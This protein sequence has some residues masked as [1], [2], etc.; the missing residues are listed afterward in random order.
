MKKIVLLLGII[1]LFAAGLRLYPSLI[2][3]MPFS[4]DAWSPIKNAELLMQ[5]TP[6][7]LN[8]KIFDGYNNYWPINSIFGALISEII[9]LPPIDSMPLLF[10]IVGALS[11]LI[12]YAIVNIFTGP[13]IS[14]LACLLFG[15]AFSHTYFT[16]GI[17]KETYASP[18]YLLLI[19]VFIH[20][21]LGSSKRVFLFTL[22][23]IALSLTHHLTLLFAFFILLSIALAKFVVN[24][25]KG[26]PVNRLELLLIFIPVLVNILYYELYANAGMGLP[27]TISDWLSIASFQLLAFTTAIFIALKPPAP[28]NSQLYLI[29][30]GSAILAGILLIV[31]LNATLV[32]GFDPAVQNQLLLFILPYFI[33]IPFEVLGVEYQKRIQ[34]L[35]IPLFW[36]IPLAA[37]L[38]YAVVSNTFIGS[39]LWI[40]TPNFMFLPV[41]ILASAGLYWLYGVAKGSHIR[42]LIKPIVITIVVTVVAINIYSLYDSVSLQDRYMGYHWLYHEQEFGAGYWIDTYTIDNNLTIAAD[43]K[44]AYMMQDYFEIKVS[45]STGFKYLNNE[46]SNQPSLLF[47]YKL[48]EKNGYI[49]SAHGITLPANWTQKTDNMNSVYSNGYSNIYSGVAKP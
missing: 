39:V 44:V 4:T 43:I 31:N 29:A 30:L 27:F 8:D 5:N 38:I 42:K 48:M 20:P 11:I 46:S 1:L 33:I 17:T 7:A 9:L 10:P 32:P 40:R 12:F 2:S 28:K 36:F 37:L 13:K 34:G 45:T 6:I 3:E 41:A 23:T 15:T 35:L 26:L 19:F 18:I 47:T 21:R 22:A 16:A 25:R 14:L 24:I 49:L